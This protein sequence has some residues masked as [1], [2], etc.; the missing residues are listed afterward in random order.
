M[1]NESRR[2]ELSSILLSARTRALAEFKGSSCSCWR[3]RS[4]A[5]S[6]HARMHVTT[7]A[8]LSYIQNGRDTKW[9]VA[10]PLYN[11]DRNN[12]RTC[13]FSTR[14]VSYSRATGRRPRSVESRSINN[15]PLT[16][17]PATSPRLPSYSWANSRA[18]AAREKEHTSRSR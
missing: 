15:H 16:I 12:P 6:I 2:L 7:A 3:W 5:P 10:R 11:G 1:K 18:K 17:F 4:Q 8:Q 13:N 14:N 9:L